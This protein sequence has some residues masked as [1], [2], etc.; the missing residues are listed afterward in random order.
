MSMLMGGW[1]GAQK[2]RDGTYSRLRNVVVRRNGT[3]IAA[4]VQSLT[5]YIS[6]PLRT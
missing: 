6:N 2:A 3:E 4:M 5:L 1:M